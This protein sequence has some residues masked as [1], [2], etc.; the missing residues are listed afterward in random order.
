MGRSTPG[1]P[2]LAAIVD[3]VVDPAATGNRGGFGG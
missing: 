1:D 2:D 3:Q